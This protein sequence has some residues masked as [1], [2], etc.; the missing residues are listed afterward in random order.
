MCLE[1]WLIAAS[2]STLDPIQEVSTGEVRIG[3][4][5]ESKN[6]RLQTGPDEFQL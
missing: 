1:G 5:P 4:K 2:P 6:G 3:G